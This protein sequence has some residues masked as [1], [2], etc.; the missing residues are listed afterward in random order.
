MRLRLKNPGALDAAIDALTRVQN[1]LGNARG[2]G[3]NASDRQDAFLTWCTSWAGRELGN[4]FAATTLT[5]QLA[6]SYNRVAFAPQLTERRMN[7]VLNGEFDIW[8]TRLGDANES[9]RALRP[10]AAYPGQIVV[11]DTS[12]FIEGVYFT[13]FDWHS[14][15]GIT[16]D[17]G[18]VRLAIPILVIDELDALKRD[19]NGRVSGRARSVLQK[20]WELHR[21]DPTKPAAIPGR[22][23]TVEVFT[24]D[25][26][27]ER[28]PVNDEEIIDRAAAIGEITGKNVLLAAGDN[29]MLY[30]AAAG[31]LK[32]VLVPRPAAESD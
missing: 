29:G 2:R 30:R 11:P 23:A 8:H 17:A 25:P 27:H 20:L 7:G 12:A 9:L 18:P 4:H 14:L 21:G 19:R 28:R 15:D 32:A 22:A 5:D 3:N 10:F 6:E 26:W 24:D 13:E 16:A 31:G 1:E